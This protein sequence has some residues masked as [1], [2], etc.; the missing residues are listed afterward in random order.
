MS[1]HLM[2]PSFLHSVQNPVPA[3]TPPTGQPTL[4]KMGLF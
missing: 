4:E 3:S 2:P 1:F